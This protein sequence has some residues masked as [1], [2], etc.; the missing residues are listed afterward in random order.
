MGIKGLQKFLRSGDFIKMTNKSLRFDQGAIIYAKEVKHTIF[1]LF[2][3]PDKTSEH[4]HAFIA[5]FDS[6]AC[7]GVREPKQVLFYLAIT[8]DED[9]H[10]FEKYVKVTS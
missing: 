10:Y 9:L 4:I 7:I 8:K 2:V 6:E 5:S 1:L 3:I